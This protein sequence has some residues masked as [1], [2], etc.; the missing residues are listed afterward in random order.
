MTAQTLDGE[1]GRRRHQ[2]RPR[3]ADRRAGRSGHHPGPG[4]AAGGRRRAVGQLRRHEAPRL[5]RAGHRARAGVHLPATATLADVLAVVDDYN[6]DPG[7]RRGAHPVP[8]PGRPRL[9]G[10]PDAPR[11]GQGRRRP[12]PGQPGPA[13]HGR[14]RRRWRARRRASRPCW[15]T[16]T[17]PSPAATWSSSGRGLTIGRPLANLLTLKRPG[18]NAAVTVV[19]TGVADL[20]A[21]TRQA[22][23]LVSAAGTPGLITPDL[24]KPG[25]R[26]GGGRGAATRAA[27][28]CPTWSTRWPRWP[29]VDVAPARR[30]RAHDPGPALPQ[31]GRGG[32]ARCGLNRP[33]TLVAH[34]EDQRPAGGRAAPTRSS[35]SRPRPTRRPASS[36][37]RSASCSRSHPSFVS[38][39]YGAGGSTR[40]RTRDIVI[41]IQH[42]A[43]ITAMAHLT[44]IAHTRDA[45]RRR[46]WRS[47]A[48]PASRTSWP[49]P[50]TRPPTRRSTRTTSRYA[51]E[52]IELIQEV[53]DFCHR[54]GRPPR[55]APAVGRR[56][57]GR[58]RPPG[59]QAGP[60]RLRHHPVLLRGRALPAHDRRA[61]RAGLHQA[62]A[63][64]DHAGHQRRARSSASPSWPAPSSRR[65]WPRG[66]PPSPTTRPRCG[67]SGVEWPPSCAPSCSPTACRACTSTRSTAPPRAAR[68]TPTSAST[69]ADRPGN[70]S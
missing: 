28:C 4:H 61:G 21:Y 62:G 44:C 60:G 13:G 43:G 66:S 39:T 9:R 10:R 22:D 41:H 37:R 45:A 16:T 54:R 20:G 32:R 15:S 46:C 12:P 53:G 33:P 29:V 42:D 8:V 35:S 17:S 24:V 52:L 30:R 59:G 19:H 67:R 1:A 64:R 2:G 68:S 48:T 23:I 27:R 51:S 14:R 36:R 40:D 56:P 6:A 38:V 11:P 69:A 55:A 34:D 18:A 7:R 26:G 70:L 5:R 47:T 63:A 31:H 50:A 25:R 57:G 49:W 65:P 58:P 3:P